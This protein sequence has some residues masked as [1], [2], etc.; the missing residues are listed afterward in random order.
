VN[1]QPAQY[2]DGMWT[3]NGWVSG[4]FYQLHWQGADGIVYDLSSTTITLDTLLTV[5]E[6][7][8]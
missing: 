7:I 3:E 6:S 1:G 8:Q 5:A 4:G 2:V